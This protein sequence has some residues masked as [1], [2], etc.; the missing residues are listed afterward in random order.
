MGIRRIPA[1]DV[2]EI[3]RLSS[4][5]SMS[6][7]QIAKKFNC[8]LQAVISIRDKKIRKDVIEMYQ[9]LSISAC[10]KRE[11]EQVLEESKQV[12]EE[13]KSQQESRSERIKKFIPLLKNSIKARKEALKDYERDQRKSSK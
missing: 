3:Y 11:I 8:S 10:P 13:T 12:L 2:I 6:L 9:A 4:T 5:Y 1:T 7:S